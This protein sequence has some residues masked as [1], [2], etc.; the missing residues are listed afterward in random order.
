VLCMFCTCCCSSFFVCLP[1]WHNWIISKWLNMGVCRSCC[2]QCFDSWLGDRKGNQ[3]VKT[4]GDGGGGHW[5]GQMEWRPTGWSLCLPLLISPCTIKSRS[6][7]LALA[8]S[9]A[10]GKRAV[11][12]LWYLQVLFMC[13]MV[14]DWYTVLGKLLFKNN[15]LQLQVTCWQN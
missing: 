9:G 15:L 10:S 14:Y 2:L 13:T 5:L 1:D 3:P 4:M 8:H 11:K 6:S 12:R 7:L